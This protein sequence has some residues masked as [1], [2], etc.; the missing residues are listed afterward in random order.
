VDLVRWALRDVR[1][2]EGVVARHH[3][4]QEV[5]VVEAAFHAGVE[6]LDEMVAF[7]GRYCGETVISIK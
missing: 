7:S 5:R 4:L 2:E 3:Y 6:K 1:S